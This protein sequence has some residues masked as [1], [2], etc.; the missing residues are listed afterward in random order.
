MH[1][2]NVLVEHFRSLVV[3]KFSTSRM[4]RQRNCCHQVKQQGENCSNIRERFLSFMCIIKYHRD[5]CNVEWQTRSHTCSTHL[6]NTRECSKQAII[7]TPWLHHTIH[8]LFHTWF[9]SF[10]IS[11]FSLF[12]SEAAAILT[13]IMLLYSGAAGCKHQR[14]QCGSTRWVYEN[15]HLF[16]E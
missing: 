1:H 5:K 13:Y 7:N 10:F 16:A 3:L 9:K 15:R 2:R 11:W 6:E 12:K 8:Y 14:E 4:Q